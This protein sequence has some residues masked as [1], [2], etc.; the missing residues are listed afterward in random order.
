MRTDY[1]FLI[2]GSGFGGSIAAYRLALAQ[3]RAGR[4]ASVGVLERGKRYNRGEFP[5]SVFRPKDWVWRDRGRRGW[6]GLFDYRRFDH[7]DVLVGSGVGGTSL[8]YLDVQIDAFDSTF[9]IVDPET[10]R[11]RWP[12]GIDWAKELKPYYHRLASVLRPTPIPEPTLKTRALRAAAQGAGAADRF[13]LLDLAIYWGE[14]GSEKGSLHPDPYQRSGPPQIGC[15]YCG[16]CYLGCNTHS[17]NTLDL[18]YL[19]LAQGLGAEVYSQRQVERIEPGAEG[20]YTVH[21]RD[22]RWNVS[23]TVSTRVLILAAGALGS[24]ELLLRARNG[25][26]MGKKRVDPTL[27]RLS[28]KLGAHFSGNGD[29][30]AVGFETN[31]LVNAMTGPTITA[32][33]DF[34]DKLNGHGF[35]VEDGGFPELVRDQLRQFGGLAS[36]RRFLRRLVDVLR[37]LGAGR[38]AGGL[39]EL[40]D[41]EEVRDALPYLVMGIDA[42]DGVMSLSPEGELQIRWDNTR[43]LPFFRELEKTLRELTETP[44]GLDGNLM[45]NP[46]W[47]AQKRLVT[48]HPLGGCPM[49]DDAATGAVDPYGAVFG[50]PD[51]YVVDGAIVPTAL[52]PNPSKTIGALAERIS[53]HLVER[54]VGAA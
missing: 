9:E 47:S 54:Y 8:I 15:G 21:F 25:Y 50:H 4:P 38:T 31:R 30:G 29:F 34:R 32:M 17:K 13:R 7:I 40:L 5:R 26:R 18:N 51:L 3:R 39:L 6:K 43:S 10:R 49:G 37:R 28:D 46:T 20:G 52:G 12:S 45:L 48:V 35:I 16:E 11:R 24:T 22:V 42:A 53:E 33:L 41:L 14:N 19:W 27:D 2:I 36:G 44:S 1:D 23:G